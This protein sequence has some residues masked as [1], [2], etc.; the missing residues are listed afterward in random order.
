MGRPR[1]DYRTTSKAT[2]L[3]FL[4]V[5]PTI[6]ITYKKWCEVIRTFNESF[7]DYVLETGDRCKL[8]FGFGDV[9]ISKKMT[10]RFRMV[11]GEEKIALPID[12]KRTKEKG[13][14]VYIFNDHTDG[15]RFRW[16]WFKDNL[17]LKGAKYLV[18][19][20]S[21]ITSRKLAEYLKK[22]PYYQHLYKEWKPQ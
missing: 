1:V 7:R 10:K 8:P 20:P 2:Y 11:E 15:Y 5:H 17:R 6:K 22:N 21:R 13:K 12:W 9:S 3:K 14:R 19:K 4:Q 16:Y 18:F